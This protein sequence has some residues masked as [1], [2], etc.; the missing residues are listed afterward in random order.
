[1]SLL[2]LQNIKAMQDGVVLYQTDSINV[3]ENGPLVA[4]GEVKL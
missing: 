2:N 1:M 4:Y 3:L